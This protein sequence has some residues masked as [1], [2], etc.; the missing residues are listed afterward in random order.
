M[1]REVLIASHRSGN[2]ANA[3]TDVNPTVVMLPKPFKLCAQCQRI[4]ITWNER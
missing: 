4:G 1:S 3:F 2:T